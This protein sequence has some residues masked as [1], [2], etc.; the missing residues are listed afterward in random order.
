[1]APL[2]SVYVTCVK[3]PQDSAY[4]FM[5]TS[6][7]VW[8]EKNGIVMLYLLSEHFCLKSQYLPC[9]CTC[10]ISFQSRVRSKKLLI[11]PKV[12]V[13]QTS[14]ISFSQ[15]IPST[16]VSLLL[17]KCQYFVLEKITSSRGDQDEVQLASH[18]TSVRSGIPSG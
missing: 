5:V 7:K 18:R 1:M 8:C 2:S 13:S 16:I 9:M 6:G 17:L 11:F 4:P 3:Y 12:T 10:Q 15:H 14:G